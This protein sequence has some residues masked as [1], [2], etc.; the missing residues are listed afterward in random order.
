MYDKVMTG[1]ISG[2]TGSL[3]QFIFGVFANGAALF[4][5][6]TAYTLRFLER[7]MHI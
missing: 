5:F 2:M 6:F 7:K 1:A 4:G 3:V